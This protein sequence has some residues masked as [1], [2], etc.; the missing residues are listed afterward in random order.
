MRLSIGAALL[1]AARWEPLT[2]MFMSNSC[3]NTP[4]VHFLSAMGRRPKQGSTGHREWALV[5]QTTRREE[6]WCVALKR[7]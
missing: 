7:D 6:M 2:K 5:N 4:R 3:H 1:C